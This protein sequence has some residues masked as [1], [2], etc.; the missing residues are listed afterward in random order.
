M[1]SQIEYR[2]DGISSIN[3]LARVLKLEP[4][5]LLALSKNSSNLYRV[6]KCID[7]EDGTQRVTY[8][9]LPPLKEVL[10]ALRKRIVDKALLPSHIAAGK[11]GTSYID[12]AKVHA[13]CKGLLS[14]DIKNFFPSIGYQAVFDAFKF[15]YKMPGEIAEVV[16]L[17]CTKDGFLVQ[18]SP[19]SGA[20]AN[21]IFF[22]REPFLVDKLAT[23]GFRYTRYYDDV[24][25]SHK[26]IDFSDRIGELRTK[27]YGVFLSKGLHPHRSNKKSNY[28]NQSGRMSVHGIVTNN[29]K[30]KPN[31]KMVSDTRAMLFQM[32]RLLKTDYSIETIISSFRS[33]NGKI[34]TLNSQGSL[35]SKEY[36]NSL[37]IL[38]RKVDESKAKKYARKAR[39]VKSRREYNQ[40]SSKLSV[41]K[42]INVKVMKVAKIESDLARRRLAKRNINFK[43][44]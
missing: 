6:A 32:E 28:T 26:S 41:L 8:D 20:L 44:D 4:Q 5:E 23:M 39:K 3:S 17:L 38:M 36:L 11:K 42:K 2:N 34:Q 21:I 27:I 43:G 16:S 1:S 12:N 10:S 33:I 29:S 22:D 40:L 7:K 9:A 15:L 18:G 24:H 35:K 37:N 19:V 14:E 30:I 13:G 31:P 25:I